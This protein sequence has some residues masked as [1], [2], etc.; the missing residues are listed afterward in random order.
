MDFVALVLYL[1]CRETFHLP[2]DLTE[3]EKLEP[4]KNA[5]AD[6]RIRLLNRLYAKK[7][8]V[9]LPIAQR[10]TT[11][12][13]TVCC[14]APWGR[15]PDAMLKA[16]AATVHGEDVASSALAFVMLLMA[17]CAV[18]HVQTDWAVQELAHKKAAELAAEARARKQAQP[19]SDDRPLEDLLSFIGTEPAG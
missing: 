1:C 8:K 5:T 11:S 7:R 18:R 13:A 16:F 15:P 3:E 19:P 12:Q 4:V 17:G 14:P 6:P 10:K 9:S 2:D